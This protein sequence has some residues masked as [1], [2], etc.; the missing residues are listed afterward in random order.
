MASERFNIYQ[1][2]YSSTCQLGK[3]AFRRV[4]LTIVIITKTI[5]C[6]LL[7]EWDNCHQEIRII[8]WLAYKDNN[9]CDNSHSLITATLSKLL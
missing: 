1:H 7:S 2:Y 8:S 5:L 3:N 6:F 4:E 9:L